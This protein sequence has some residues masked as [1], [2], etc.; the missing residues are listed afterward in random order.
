MYSPVQLRNTRARVA[1]AA[2]TLQKSDSLITLNSMDSTDLDL[3]DVVNYL[4]PG[5][6]HLPG[7]RYCG[8]GTRLDLRLND[9]DT[10]RP[11]NEPIDRVDRAAME[12]D[13]AY[14]KHRDLR[15]RHAADKEMIQKLLKIKKPTRRERCERCLVIPILFLKQLIA[16]LIIKCMDCFR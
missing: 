3:V 10:P 2:A 1:A 14:T 12:H 16:G 13:I 4:V 8:P 9:D 7:M 6:K 11:G 15:G 5:E